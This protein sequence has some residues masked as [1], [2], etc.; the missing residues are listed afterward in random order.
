[1][2]AFWV[3][4]TPI[5]CKV[6][7]K[8]CD[9]TEEMANY[10]VIWDRFS[11]SPPHFIYLFNY[12]FIY[13][14]SCLFRTPFKIIDI[15]RLV[16]LDW[17]SQSLK[18]V[19]NYFFAFSANGAISKSANGSQRRLRRLDHRLET[20]SALLNY[21]LSQAQQNPESTFFHI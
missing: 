10:L 17:I 16:F 11:P 14:I 13:F 12:L 2:L 9:S 18:I 21:W 1:M 4:D 15:K 19:L 20:L 8:Y 6:L 3:W 7:A 5:Y